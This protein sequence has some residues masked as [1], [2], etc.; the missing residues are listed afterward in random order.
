MGNF[1]TVDRSTL[2]NT[3]HLNA[4]TLLEKG[5][6]IE[7]PRSDGAEEYSYTI[8]IRRRRLT[9]RRLEIRRLLL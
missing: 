8:P 5:L 2:A 3:E 4:K 7:N 9:T 6:H 1:Y